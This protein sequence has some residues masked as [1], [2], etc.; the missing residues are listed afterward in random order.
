LIQARRLA[1]GPNANNGNPEK[2]P[3]N[4]AKAARANHSSEIVNHFGKAMEYNAGAEP[5]A[6][7]CRSG[8]DR[9]TC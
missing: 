9:A 8:S 6:K 4:L 1:H 7:A 5:T 2:R 3:P